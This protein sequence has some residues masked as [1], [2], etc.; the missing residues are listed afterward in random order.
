VSGAPGDRWQ[1]KLDDETGPD[2]VALQ[3]ISNDDVV[4]W[5]ML[6]EEQAFDL[7]RGAEAMAQELKN[8]KAKDH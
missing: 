6:T 4:A 5:L 1:I 2:M 8:R 7:S 3:I